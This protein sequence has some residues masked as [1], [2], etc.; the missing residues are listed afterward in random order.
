[1]NN[2][3]SGVPQSLLEDVIA[4]IRQQVL[5]EARRQSPAASVATRLLTAA[6]AAAYLGRSERAVRQLIF[7][8]QIPVVKI[9][10]NVRIDRR[11]LDTLIMENRV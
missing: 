5:D 2:N 9:G 6:E 1:M 4:V 8:R 7:K 10:R 3:I 11:D